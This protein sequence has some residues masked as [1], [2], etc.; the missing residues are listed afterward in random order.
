MNQIVKSPGLPTSRDFPVSLS[1]QCSWSALMILPTMNFWG[2][3]VADTFA[4]RWIV[5]TFQ[6]YIHSAHLPKISYAELLTLHGR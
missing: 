3:C 5:K 2:R 4:L 6:C 1:D